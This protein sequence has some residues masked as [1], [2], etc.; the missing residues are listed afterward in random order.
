MS[1]ECS[2]RI[3]SSLEKCFWDELITQKSVRDHFLMY[4]NEKLSFQI[5]LCNH[6]LDG[7]P[8]FCFDVSGALADY[9]TVREVISMPAH[10]CL[11]G[12]D[13]GYLR[14]TPG[15]YPDMLRP[16]HYRGGIPLPVGQLRALWVDVQIPEGVEVP[17]EETALTFSF[18]AKNFSYSKPWEIEMGKV[19][20]YV[21]V[22]PVSL[23]AQTLIRTEWFYSDCV[24]EA[25]YTEAFSEKHWEMLEKFVKCAVDNGI[26]MI[27]TPVF[28]PELDTYIG[29]ERLTTQLVKITVT[30]KDTY[31]FDYTLLDRWLDMCERLG[32]TYYEIPH[33][34]TQ[35]GAKAAPKFIA[36]VDGEEKRI[37]GWETD[38]TGEAYGTFLSQFIPSLVAYFQSRGVDNRCYYH[39]SDEPHLEQLEQYRACKERVAPYL[40]GYPI[41]DALS[42][43]GFYQTGVLDIPV[44]YINHSH[45]FLEADIAE[46]W[47]YYCGAP[48]YTTGRSF[49]HPTARTRILGVQLYRHRIKGFL[50]WGYNFYRN[51]HSYNHVD[52]LGCTDAEYWTSPGNAFLVYPGTD[53]T[54][55]ESIRLNALREAMDDMRALQLCES[56]LGR[57]KTEELIAVGTLEPLT[58]FAYPKN[59]EY[60]LSLH[61]RV[62]LAV[63]QAQTK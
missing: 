14:T 53:G 19:S 38:S 25:Y 3:V 39:I 20:A 47:V 27:L 40:E 6:T 45:A 36:T 12:K 2:M 15:L 33:F 50:H 48:E 42:D 26:N 10:S 41:I 13:D 63:E 31:E 62:L 8:E 21:R 23:P 22:S 58:F 29:G 4:R 43:F 5:A 37:F 7:T 28:T 30:G 1:A 55:W 16:M 35:W 24:A 60:L 57:E 61:D 32:V 49:S 59:G 9:V 54:V 56:L 51:C 18:T 46:P 44:P 52:V 11:G 17:A 34:F